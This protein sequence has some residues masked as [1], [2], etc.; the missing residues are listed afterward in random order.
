MN[1]A[2]EVQIKL[3][4][5]RRYLRAKNLSGVFLTRRNNFAWLTA[6]GDNHVS[7]GQ[8]EGAA[9]LFL[10]ARKVYALANHIE[11]PRLQ[12]EELPEGFELVEF[13]WSEPARREKILCRLARGRIASDAP[14][15]H[16]PL[17]PDDWNAL[18]YSLL[19]SEV[20][21]YRRLAAEAAIALEAAALAVKPGMTEHEVAGDLAWLCAE[22]GMDPLV[23]LIAADERIRAFRHPIP[24]TKKVR[25]YCLLVLCAERGGLVAAASRLISFGRIPAD[26]RRRHLA[27][28]RV[29]AAL[30]VA[31]QV[32][33]SFGEVFRIAQRTYREVGFAGE[34]R[35]HHQ[36]GPTGYATRE[37]VA[38]ARESRK[39]QANQPIAWNP[40]IAGTKSED[41]IL[42]TE[43]GPEILTATGRWP[44]LEINP[45][46]RVILR[47]DWRRL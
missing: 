32:G 41:T 28:C 45:A 3:E 44:M 19:P 26:L 7:L 15:L 9:T 8:A 46:G 24:T 36:G 14:L 12:A 29:D 4:R 22:R 21:R 47:P 20:Q 31:S 39:I 43:A 10:T 30:I 13:P 2:E 23:R 16:F 35:H 25:R 42:A 11:A 37:F 5:A 27:V 17:L 18:R 38:T 40:S 33:R 6:G 1:R 34:W